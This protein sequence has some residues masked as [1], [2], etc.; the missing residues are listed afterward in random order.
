[1]LRSSTGLP[2]IWSIIIGFQV[3]ALHSFVPLSNSFRPALIAGRLDDGGFTA[4]S[5]ID[6]YFPLKAKVFEVF[7]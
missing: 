6:C 1:M 3:T 4:A 7:W 5:P 2:W